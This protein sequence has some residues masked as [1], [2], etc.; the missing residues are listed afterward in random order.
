MTPQPAKSN[1][2]PATPSQLN[3]SLQLNN[4]NKNSNKSK[5]SPPI[6]NLTNTRPTGST[7]LQQ[8]Q[9]S[10]SGSGKKLNIQFNNNTV[11]KNNTQTTGN[12]K[13]SPN[14]LQLQQ[15]QLQYLQ[16]HFDLNIFN[17]TGN[18]V[19]PSGTGGTNGQLPS[20]AYHLNN[21]KNPSNN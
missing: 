11:V 16:Q 6:I 3:R 18:L 12:A 19:S 9:V 20:I 21:F 15:Q 14:T 8:H 2:K 5:V 13:L 4:D 10:P 7:S 17:A 1:S